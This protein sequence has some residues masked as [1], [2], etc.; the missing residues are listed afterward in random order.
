MGIPLLH[1]LRGSVRIES[2]ETDGRDTQHWRSKVEAIGGGRNVGRK[3]IRL[4]EDIGNVVTLI[5]PSVEINRSIEDAVSGV[6]NQTP[7][8]QALGDAETRREIVFVGIHQACGIAE[9]SAD[10][11]RRDATV[12]KDVGIGVIAIP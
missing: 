12:P 7:A 5:A 3:L 4:G 8:R 11:N 6:N 2:G 9:L 1:I 10:E